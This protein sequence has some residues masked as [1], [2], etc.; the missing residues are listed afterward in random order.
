MRYFLLLFLLQASL[1]AAGQSCTLALG[2]IVKD[3]DGKVL[4]GATIWIASLEKGIVASPDGLFEINALCPGKYEVEVKFVGYET[5]RLS[6]TLPAPTVVIVLHPAIEVLHGV[7][8]EGQH[9]RQHSLSQSA[10][11]LTAGDLAVNQGKPL[12]EILQTIPGVSAMMTGPAVYKPVIHGLHGQRILLL[13]NG[14]RQDGQQWGNEHA[15]EIDT[16][17]AS[18]IEVVKGAETVRYGADA[19]GGVVI[20]NPPPL[21]Y[22]RGLRGELNTGF[23]SNNRMGVFSGTLQGGFAQPEK[24][25]WRLQGTVKK[26]GDYHA[27]KYNLSNTGAEEID[28]SAAIGFKKDEQGVEFFVSSFNTT[29]GILRSAHT[30]SLADLQRSVEQKSPAYVDD[31]TYRIDN[32]RQQINHH[33]IKVSAFR[34]TPIGKLTFLYGGQFNQRKEFD[35]RRGGRSNKPSLSLDLFSHAVD[36]SLDHT[37][38]K[39]SGSAGLNFTVKDNT[40]VPGTG[41]T[42]LIPDY[43]QTSA[44]LFILEKLRTGKWLFEGGVRVDHQHLKV[45]TFNQARELLKPAYDFHF[46]AGMLGISYYFNSQARLISNIGMSTRPPHVSELYS[47]GLHHGSASIEQG[48]LGDGDDWNITSPVRMEHAWKW[49]NT[50]QLTNEKVALEA[51]LH[52]NHIDNFVYLQAAGTR[53]TIRGYFPF[54]KF[55]QTD[56]LLAGSDV[57]F[58]WT[59]SK[60][61]TYAGKFSWLYANDLVQHDR[62]PFMPP[63]TLDNTITLAWPAVG[64]L[65]DVYFALGLPVAFKQNRAPL[66]VYPEDIPD[67]DGHKNFDYMPAPPGYALV[68]AEMGTVFPAGKHSMT[69]SIKGEN[70]L[71]TS[72]RNY[73]NRLRYFADDI[74]RNISIRIKYDLLKND[75]PEKNQTP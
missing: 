22:Q 12:G 40:N 27:A 18:E 57:S 47:Q 1:T 54:F 5:K 8:V 16:Y 72:Y 6:I 61:L 71:N 10:T 14:V 64:K 60:R 37:L 38:G 7:T 42:P 58:R 67:Y 32:P 73:M 39:L 52:V 45:M 49:V 25:S 51:S 30:G 9:L 44:G 21:S 68:S 48:L 3:A 53:L 2:G 41:I 55:N 69:V 33:L 17:I 50:L 31:F 15:P 66:T 46:F 59:M 75:K 11:I 4:P 70:L 20:V 24:G 36:V 34:H 26:G 56:A 63:P 74:G 35:V 28:F 65:K 29:I 62:L 43:D 19:L 13:N 23:V